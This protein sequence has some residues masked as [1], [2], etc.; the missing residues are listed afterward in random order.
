MLALSG[1]WLEVK[2]P[3]ICGIEILA[4]LLAILYRIVISPYYSL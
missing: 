1:V 2:T 3:G 4:I